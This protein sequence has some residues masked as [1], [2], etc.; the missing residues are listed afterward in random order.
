MVVKL[1]DYIRKNKK[2][3][4]ILA[5]VFIIWLV[6]MVVDQ[7]KGTP[8]QY[9]ALFP[10]IIL[11]V[12]ISLFHLKQEILSEL[13]NLHNQEESHKEELHEELLNRIENLE[14]LQGKTVKNL[15]QNL[16]DDL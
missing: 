1:A 16:T 15:P 12:Y 7:I 13:K 8:F 14:R 10:L 4:T 2:S 5:I 9:L 6:L 3:F 11:F